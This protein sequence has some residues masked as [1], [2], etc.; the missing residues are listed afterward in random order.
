MLWIGVL[1]VGSFFLVS[2]FLFFVD[3]IFLVLRDN[4][5]FPQFL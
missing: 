4:Q 1:L 5:A 3:G 2:Y